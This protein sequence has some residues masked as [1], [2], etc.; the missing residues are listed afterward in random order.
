MV[1]T[2]AYHSLSI[3]IVA[4]H[5]VLRDGPKEVV[6]SALPAVSS[7]GSV[8]ADAVEELFFLWAVLDL[9]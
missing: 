3:H 9:I 5:E 7:V 4:H 8:L 1:D 2:K 6:G